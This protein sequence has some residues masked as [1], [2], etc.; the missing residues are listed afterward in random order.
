MN[1]INHNHG[2]EFEISNDELDKIWN[3]LFPSVDTILFVD[4]LNPQRLLE[5]L[6]TQEGK[7]YFQTIFKT[8][9]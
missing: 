7:T 3:K 8:E 1:L 9:N 4:A 5:W 6:K 2:T